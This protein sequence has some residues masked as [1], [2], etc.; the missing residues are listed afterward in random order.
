[1]SWSNIYKVASAQVLSAGS[2][3]FTSSEFESQRNGDE[4]GAIQCNFTSAPGATTG[5][6]FLEARMTPD[7]AWAPCYLPDGTRIEA[8]LANINALSSAV[9]AVDAPMLPYMR[10]RSTDATPTNACT[11]DLWVVL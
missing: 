7:G 6:V 1:M 11:L 10:L 2:N 3:S 9:L 5:T 4:R 8:D